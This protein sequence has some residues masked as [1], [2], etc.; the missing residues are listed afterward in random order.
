MR[1][2]E[3]EEPYPFPRSP[4]YTHRPLYSK[5]VRHLLLRKDDPQHESSSSSSSPPPSPTDEYTADLRSCHN[6]TNLAL[7]ISEYNSEATQILLAPSDWQ[8][9]PKKLS[10]NVKILTP[11]CAS[12]PDFALPFF[13]SVTHLDVLDHIANDDW[14]A[15][16]GLAHLPNLT[17]LAVEGDNIREF[18]LS[19]LEHCKRLVVLVQFCHLRDLAPGLEGR[20]GEHPK[21]VLMKALSDVLADWERGTRGEKDFWQ[22]AEDILA[23]SS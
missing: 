7:W 4:P 14:D 17:H 10:M 19:T 21:L 2:F 18:V 13:G 16:K 22:R 15:W 1:T 20:K 11:D 3:E 12:V 5:H 9:R 6:A 8:Y 23:Q